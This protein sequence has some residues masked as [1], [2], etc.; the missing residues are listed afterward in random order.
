MC[1]SSNPD[2]V[3]P[4]S[5]RQVTP[6][7]ESLEV[8]GLVGRFLYIRSSIISLPGGSTRSSRDI[9]FV[10]LSWVEYGIGL[11]VLVTSSIFTYLFV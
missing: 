7:T 10:Q 2:R 11:L 9:S 1:L 6:R 3:V 5:N 4:I 8:L